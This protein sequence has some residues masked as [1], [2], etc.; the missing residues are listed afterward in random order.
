MKYEEYKIEDFLIS[1]EFINWVTEPTVESNLFWQKWLESNREKIEMINQAREIIMAFQ[2]KQSAIDQSDYHEVLGNVI[3]EKYSKRRVLNER[4]MQA[5]NKISNHWWKIAASLV[6]LISLS[7]YVFNA[8]Q[9][10]ESLQENHVI[11]KI[12]PVGQ[13]STIVLPDSSIVRLNSES[14][15]AYDEDFMNHRIVYL[16]GEAFF[17]VT[18][19]KGIFQV[20]TNRLTTTVLGTKFDVKAY[21]NDPKESISLQSGRVRIDQMNDGM[22]K[23]LYLNPGEKIVLNENSGV[24]NKEPVSQQDIAWKDGILVFQDAG[25]D[26]FKKTLERWYAV[27]IEVYGTPE[28]NWK[29]TGKFDN[30]SLELVLEGVKFAENIDYEIENKNVKIYL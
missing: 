22:E 17:T 12:N 10:S 5:D 6:F 3:A 13:K 30:E 19:G 14:K 26:E 23:P 27:N 8:Y 24:I 28:D 18:K 2:M 15:I 16:E 11:T 25:F 20:K 1:S 7:F 4:S 29:I 21:G 9:K